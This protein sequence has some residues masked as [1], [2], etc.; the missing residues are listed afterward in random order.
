MKRCPARQMIG[1]GSYYVL[2]PAAVADLVNQ[3][4]NPYEENITVEDL[5]IKVG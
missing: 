3:Y 5:Y 4:F 2:D 1:D